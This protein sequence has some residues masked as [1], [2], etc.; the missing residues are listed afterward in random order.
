[1]RKIIR[2]MALAVVICALAVPAGAEMI[3][4]GF[5]TSGSTAG[6]EAPYGAMVARLNVQAGDRVEKGD[7]IATLSTTKVYAPC[8]GTVSGVFGQEGDSVESVTGRYGGVMYIE[9][10]GKYTITAST[11][12]AYNVSENKFIHIGEEVFLR[13]TADGSHVG[14]GMVTGIADDGSYTVEA[15]AGEF[16][17]EETVGIFR[18]ADHSASSRIGRGKV[19]ATKPVAVGGSGSIIRMLVANGDYVERGELLFETVEGGLDGLYSPGSEVISPVSGIV[20]SVEAEEGAEVAKGGRIVSIHADESMEVQ[21]PVMESELSLIQVGQEVCVEFAW[22]M[23]QTTV[24]DGVVTRIS[25]LN[26]AETGDP[27]YTACVAFEPDDTVRMGMTVL[28]YSRE[29]GEIDE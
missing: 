5:V 15:T 21:I 2:F 25:Y 20:A 26:S 28:V 23:E 10:M 14:K 9:P 6:A 24:F 12:K 22:D 18:K 27:V 29:D 4:E 17:M 8:E 11:E 13:C 1:M 19:A 16:S 3:F 7:V